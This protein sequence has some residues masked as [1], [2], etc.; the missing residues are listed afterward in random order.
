MKIVGDLR[1]EQLV[2]PIVSLEQPEMT[3]FGTHQ[4]R[5]QEPRNVAGRIEKV[6]VL[7]VKQFLLSDVSNV[8]LE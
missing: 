2:F 4:K 7:D 6:D 5:K 8:R 3:N 1:F